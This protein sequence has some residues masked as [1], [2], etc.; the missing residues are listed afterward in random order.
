VPGVGAVWRSWL[1]PLSAAYAGVMTLRN[2]HY[3]RPGASRRATVPVISVGNLTVG[4]TGKTPMVID[5]ARRLRDLGHRPAILTRG[6]KARAGETADEV[7]EFHTAIPGVAVVVDPD[8]V[9]GAQSAS[10]QHGA[11]CVVLD[12]GFQHRRLARDLDIVLVDALDPWGGGRVLPAGRLREP[13]AGLRRASLIVLTRTNQVEP[14]RVAAIA[15][16]CA[17]LAPRVSLLRAGIE[18]EACVRRDGTRVEEDALRRGGAVGVCGLGNP[19]TFQRLVRDLAIPTPWIV[20]GDHHHYTAA[21]ARRIKTQAAASGASWVVTTR[22]DW[23]KLL[24][25]WPDDGPD[26]VRVDI[27]LRW[28]DG[29]EALLSPLRAVFAAGR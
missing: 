28:L 20:F 16:E 26:L 2:R 8:R 19:E 14:A 22:K 10:E 6:Y 11:D 21:D 5:L 24:A 9:R 29:E 25:L 3:D 23:V 12:D 27:R 4:G 18:I 7:L 17:R 15:A 13:Q 1:A